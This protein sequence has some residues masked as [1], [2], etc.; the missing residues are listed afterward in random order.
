MLCCFPL[1][2][3]LIAAADSLGRVLLF[4]SRLATTAVRIWKGVREARFAWTEDRQQ[5]PQF[6]DSDSAS[7]PRSSSGVRSKR[8]LSLA[9]YAPQTGLLSLWALRHGP[10]LR[11]I[12][13]G[14]QC[15][16]FTVYDYVPHEK[17]MLVASS[18]LP[19]PSFL[20][21][22]HYASHALPPHLP[23]FFFRSSTVKAVVLFCVQTIPI[24]YN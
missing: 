10:C 23:T 3:K 7:G 5:L 8:V 19:H 4:D 2:G 11:S 17:E 20:P 16:I 14:Q 12:P 18:S 15:H 22:S 9:I 24:S 6:S 13:V 21:A 1:G